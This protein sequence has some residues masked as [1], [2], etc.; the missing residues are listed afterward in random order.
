MDMK[1][2]SDNFENKDDSETDLKEAIMDLKK[3]MND[4]DSQKE[5]TRE[6]MLDGFKSLI[7]C[8]KLGPD[9]RGIMKQV[10]SQGDIKKLR[11]YVDDV[12]EAFS[13]NELGCFLT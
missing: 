4:Y 6:N 12:E 8:L 10:A 13:R 5:G 7:D 3:Y 1:N 9:T 11:Y 2:F